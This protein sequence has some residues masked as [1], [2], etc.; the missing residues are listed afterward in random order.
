MSK[1]RFA[2]RLVIYAAHFYAVDD[3]VSMDALSEASRLVVD[4]LTR[5]KM[6]LLENVGNDP[7]AVTPQSK[8]ECANAFFITH[9]GAT[10]S[11]AL[12]IDSTV[13]SHH[14][15][16][17]I[18]TRLYRP[19]S[20]K[21]RIVIMFVHGGGWMQGNLDTHDCLCRELANAFNMEV[22]SVDYRLA[23]EH[24]FPTPLNDVLSVY[25]QL[26]EH[27]DKDIILAG[28]SAGGNL[29]AALCIRLHET[30]KKK[31]LAQVLFYPALSNNF[32]SESF[33]K[34]GEL[35]TLTRA[36]TL[37]FTCQYAGVGIDE[38]TALGNKLIFPLMEDDVGAFPKTIVVSAEHDVLIDENRE[39]V[40]KLRRGGVA[41]THIIVPGTV[42]GFMTYAREFGEI[43]PDVLMRILN[44][45]NENMMLCFLGC[46]IDSDRF[47]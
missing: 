45:M 12:T 24:I 13:H 20:C 32:D 31:P 47:P 16:Y 35:A 7:S 9:S 1:I 27:A 17:R 34:F 3:V 18:P 28:D 41:A 30:Q 14:D 4:D 10:A 44:W 38:I 21:P 40:E 29:C 33:Q 22:V 42:H 39:F 5:V 36:G 46:D 25:M 8:R 19:S 23:P 37:A 26:Q 11:V 43:I 2:L 6:Q 15:D